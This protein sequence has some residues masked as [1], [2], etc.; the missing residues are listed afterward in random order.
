MEHEIL[1]I[2]ITDI[3]GEGAI[4]HDN[5]ITVTRNEVRD[6]FAPRHNVDLNDLDTVFD[7]LQDFGACDAVE[8]QAHAYRFERKHIHDILDVEQQVMSESVEHY[9]DNAS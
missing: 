3:W 8:N 6:Y 9:M 4:D 2:A 5:G 1:A 7:F